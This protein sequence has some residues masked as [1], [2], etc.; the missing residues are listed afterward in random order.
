MHIRS[1]LTRRR[2]S[3]PSVFAWAQLVAA[4]TGLVCAAAHALRE[5][6]FPALFGQWDRLPVPLVITASA[7]AAVVFI[8]RGHPGR[9]MTAASLP[10]AAHLLATVSLLPLSEWLSLGSWVRQALTAPLAQARIRPAPVLLTI[11]DWLCMAA[12]AFGAVVAAGLAGTAR[13]RERRSPVRPGAP[14]VIAVTSVFAIA[15]YWAGEYLLAKGGPPGWGESTRPAFVAL[16]AAAVTALIDV[17]TRWAAR[18]GMTTVAAAS[19]GVSGVVLILPLAWQLWPVAQRWLG[20]PAPTRYIGVGMVGI[21]RRQGLAEGMFS[22]GSALMRVAV[23][24]AAL[25]AA[26]RAATARKPAALR[27]RS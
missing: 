20:H 6:E 14:A 8:M 26:H 23:V 25:T 9:A 19:A 1:T 18:E 15:A 27:P 4:A 22:L 12:I 24:L 7:A 21:A 5:Q 2:P 16:A 10:L 13:H 11:S 3:V 17:H